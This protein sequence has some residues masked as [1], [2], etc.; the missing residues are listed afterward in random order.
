MIHTLFN[1]DF[2]NCTLVPQ[3]ERLYEHYPYNKERK[4]KEAVTTLP[5]LNSSR[6]ESFFLSHTILPRKFPQETARKFKNPKIKIPF[7]NPIP[8]N[9]KTP[10]SL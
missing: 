10:K 5:R 1:V 2:L 6:H 9:T 8:I 7:Q 4:D 3:F